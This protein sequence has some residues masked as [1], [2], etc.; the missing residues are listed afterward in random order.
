MR[1]TVLTGCT[2]ILAIWL[3]SPASAQTETQPE[4]PTTPRPH[5]NANSPE[6]NSPSTD[7]KV[8]PPVNVK[9]VAPTRVTPTARS[10][11]V[12]LEWVAVPDVTGYRVKRGT[13]STGPWVKLADVAGTQTQYTDATAVNGTPY[14][15]VVTAVKG[16]SE[17]DPSPPVSATPVATP[18]PRLD[19]G[20]SSNAPV[21]NVKMDVLIKEVAAD[22]SS[23][24]VSP[25]PKAKETTV[26]ASQ[27][28]SVPKELQVALKPYRSGDRV[29]V[30]Y[31]PGAAQAQ[32]K[33]ISWQGIE[34]SVPV[35]QRLGALLFPLLLLP[36][37]LGIFTKGDPRRLYVGLDGRYSNSKFQM[38]VW[39]WVLVST[40]LAATLLRAAY[41][42]WAYVGG[43]NIPENLVVLSGLSA[44]TFA[45]AKGITVAKVDLNGNAKQPAAAG[46]LPPGA[47][48]TVIKKPPVTLPGAGDLTHDDYGDLDLGDSQMLVITVLAILVY[49]AQV[50][51]FLGVIE[52]RREVT[53]PDVDTTILTL[54]GVGQGAYLTKKVAGVAGK[55]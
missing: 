14:F 51:A 55:D 32:L 5:I 50:V 16:T 17:S 26:Q 40:Y 1:W 52:F 10:A 35:L 3:G 21:P 11:S 54:F 20:G 36:L 42:G 41:S 53:L 31:S 22:Q 7:S 34:G 28:L 8:P 9:P 4:A 24:V 46:P 19:G 27:T 37:L 29:R 33:D 48:V 45:A 30:T 43:V 39:F 12:N 6:A 15:Y 38:V 47:G 18:T 49:L 44:F 23:L 2:L 25:D 13:T